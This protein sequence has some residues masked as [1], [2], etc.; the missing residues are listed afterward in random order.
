MFTHDAINHIRNQQEQ[1]KEKKNK[2]K[3]AAKQIF[4]VKMNDKVGMKLAVH[5]KG[6]EFTL[7]FFFK[8]QKNEA[9]LTF[10]RHFTAASLEAVDVH[11][12]L[13][14]CV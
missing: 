4:H 14:I 11:V 12:R 10:V 6:S 5:N 7:L 13:P 9:Q 1:G 8:I 2:K 3:A